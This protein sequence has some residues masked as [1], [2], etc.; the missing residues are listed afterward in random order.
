MQY[1][2]RSH[3]GLVR[4]MNQ[5]G[6]AVHTDTPPWRLLVVADGMGGASAG[7]V[8]SQI[9]VSEV[10]RTVLTHLSAGDIDAVE[11]LQ[12]AISSANQRIWESARE[13]P[14]YNGMGTTVVA[15]LT[16]G[17]ALVFAHVGD[18]R[19]YFWHA[20]ELR[21]VTHDHSLVGELVRRGQLTEE[22][23]LHHP[24][25]NIVTR[26]LGTTENSAPDIDVMS[27]TSKDVVLLCSDGLS[28][29]IPGDELAEFLKSASTASTQQALD[30]I[31]DTLL[32]VAL[33]RGAPDNIT[34]IL[35]VHG[36]EG[37]A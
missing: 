8:A 5:D 3:I 13:N 23:A 17:E 6:Y 34:L 11:V 14:A 36:E 4:Q 27:W 21:Q 15:V 29:L 32:R 28:N 37:E 26:S 18:S 1:A 22:E 19:G 30:H 24:Q 16:D 9:A 20:D 31:A 10:S 2:A 25:R 33:E 7:E 12:H 35:A